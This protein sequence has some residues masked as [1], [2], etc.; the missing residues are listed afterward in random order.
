MADGLLIKNVTLADRGEYL[1]RAFQA[2][3]VASN[4]AEQIITLKVHR[5]L[6]TI[7]IN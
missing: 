1:C 2:S 3:S 6:F 7:F 4:I 5:K